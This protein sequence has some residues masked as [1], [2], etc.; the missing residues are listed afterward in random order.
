MNTGERPPNHAAKPV[1]E[2]S[3][4]DDGA[5]MPQSNQSALF[6]R[7]L[8]LCCVLAKAATFQKSCR[9]PYRENSVK[10][11]LFACLQKALIGR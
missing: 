2:G 11:D 5:V 9:S 7:T 4:L 10:V 8:L 6:F 1:P 3:A